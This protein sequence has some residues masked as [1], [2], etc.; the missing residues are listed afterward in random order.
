MNPSKA[1]NIVMKATFSEGP[2]GDE[3]TKKKTDTA[4][5]LF[6]HIHN[7]NCFMT[8]INSKQNLNKLQNTV[9]LGSV[10]SSSRVSKNNFIH[11][12]R[13]VWEELGRMYWMRGLGG[14]VWI[15]VKLIYALR[16]DASAEFF[17][18]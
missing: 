9:V 14:R 15:E 13:N 7:N 6:P 12:G 3:E 1:M 2:R 17:Q 18:S 10:F 11:L 16:P 5:A 4:N 8:L